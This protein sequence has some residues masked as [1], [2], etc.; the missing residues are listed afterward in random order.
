MQAQ[1]ETSVQVVRQR[2]FNFVVAILLVFTVVGFPL[3][4]L[5]YLTTNKEEQAYI[6]VQEDGTFLKSG[7]PWGAALT[8]SAIV[9]T[10][11][12]SSSV[13]PRKILIAL[14][15]LTAIVLIPIWASACFSILGL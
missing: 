7:V 10:S 14:A 11:P 8:S 13:T 9:Q 12:N 4:V 15:V 3:Y 1:T 6:E 2:Q 5:W